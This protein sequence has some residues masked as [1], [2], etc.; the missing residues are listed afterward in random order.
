MN[1]LTFEKIE[2]FSY[3]ISNI[4][5][6]TAVYNG[7]TL[8]FEKLEHNKKEHVPLDK[9]KK[10]ISFFIKDT[11]R[12]SFEES[13]ISSVPYWPSWASLPKP[14]TLVVKEPLYVKQ[15]KDYCKIFYNTFK[16]DLLALKQKLNKEI[17]LFVGESLF[18]S[19]PLNDHFLS[20]FTNR[21]GYADIYKETLLSFILYGEV[22]NEGTI[23]IDN[24]K[25]Q[26]IYNYRG[27]PALTYMFKRI[28]GDI[29]KQV[30][31]P[32]H[33]SKFFTYYKYDMYS[34]LILLLNLKG[35]H[36][37]NLNKSFDEF[38]KVFQIAVNSSASYTYLYKLFGVN[39]DLLLIV[40]SNSVVN[41]F[42]EFEKFVATAEKRHHAILYEEDLP[43]DKKMT[44]KETFR[45]EDFLVKEHT[46]IRRA[47]RELEAMEN[48]CNNPVLSKIGG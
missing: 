3:V 28:V 33:K 40:P 21:V 12:K 30:K 6:R 13:F 4:K 7:N 43:K 48:M 29:F 20:C 22:S 25:Y 9:L 18:L 37:Y 19:D 2:E 24:D 44:N 39:R 36:I 46:S 32:L 15:T 17:D 41:N 14:A 38:L 10:E 35:P 26:K 8:F 1:K 27:S 31:E 34:L 23:H 5:N 45:Y 16:N 47:I 42:L 11:P